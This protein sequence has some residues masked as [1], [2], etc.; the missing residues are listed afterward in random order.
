MAF[1]FWYLVIGLVFAAGVNGWLKATTLFYH[2]NITGFLTATI[3]WPIY[4]V[5]LINEIR[6]K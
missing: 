2:L 5:M 4:L 3:L 1:L 6:G